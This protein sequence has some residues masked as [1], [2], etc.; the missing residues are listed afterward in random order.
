MILLLDFFFS[1]SVVFERLCCFL[2]ISPRGEDV[3]Q[4]KL[5]WKD[6]LHNVN[7][8]V[9]LGMVGKAVQNVYNFQ[10][11]NFTGNCI[12][13]LTDVTETKSSCTPTIE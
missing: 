8:M 2:A 9:S 13:W 5:T 12:V 1:E 3:V 10:H 11:R 7:S 6:I 4:L